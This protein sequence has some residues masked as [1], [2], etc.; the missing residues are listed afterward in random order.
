ML[1][2]QLYPYLK[3][4][5]FRT[6][7]FRRFGIGEIPDIDF[8]P[9]ALKI[10]SPRV[11]HKSDVGGVV[12]SVCD[13][14]G[15]AD[16]RTRIVRSLEAHGIVF[17]PASDGFI[18]TEMVRGEELFAGVVDD[19]IFGKTILFGKG[20]VLLELYRDVCYIDLHAPEAEIRRALHSTRISRLFEGYRGGKTT[21]DSA[22]GLITAF[23]KF[24]IDRP[25]IAECDLNPL[26]LNDEGFTVVDARIRIH[27]ALPAAPRPPRR[28]SDFF[29]NRTV[30][31]I[32]ASLNP[33]KVGY[34]IAKNALSF[35][36]KLYLVNARGGTFEGREIYRSIDDIDD[37]IDTAVITIPSAHVLETIRALIP[38]GVKNIIVVSAG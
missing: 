23:Q 21:L 22:V 27:D 9:V 31:V 11:I 2:S 3:Q 33:Q 19:P 30:A 16:A 1:E 13:A 6:P 32:G 15:L 35:Q 26:I 17:D 28:R 7:R 37:T 34:A 25:E 10:E 14:V 12:L 4:G 8:F 5:G 29:D 36:G 38:K 20:G 24:L 18:A